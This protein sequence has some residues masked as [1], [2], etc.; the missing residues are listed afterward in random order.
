MVLEF[1][2]ARLHKFN[3]EGVTKAVCDVIISDEF[4]VKGI[5]VIQGRN[6]LFVGMPRE[7][8]KDGKWYNNAF[9]LTDSC[10]RALAQVVLAVYEDSC[11]K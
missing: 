9:P 8:G 5:R 4:L 10:K 1:R 7:Q 6:G 11:D 3:G 2:V